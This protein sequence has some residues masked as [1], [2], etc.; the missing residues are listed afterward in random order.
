MTR[1]QHNARI[2]ADARTTHASNRRPALAATLLAVMLGLAACKPAPNE[3]TVGQKV[4]NAVAQAQT[5]ASE[6]KAD[7]KE[8]TAE[9]RADAS[10]AAN[11]AGNAVRDAAITASVN[12]KLAA[13]PALSAL[14]INV[15][16]AAGR[17]S[18][19]GD[20]PDTASRE[21]ATT[22]ARSVEGVVDVNNQLTLKPK[23]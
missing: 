16:T 5:K 14:R 13:D 12:G 1:S 17:V 8:A 19:M 3:P 20:A 6:M 4:D 10:Q 18:L 11:N 9:A 22:L 15:D 21:R 7:A 23:E 2:G